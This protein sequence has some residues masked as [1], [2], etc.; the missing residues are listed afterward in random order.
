MP[1]PGQA[2]VLGESLIAL[3]ELIPPLRR[4]FARL[5]TR[6]RHAPPPSRGSDAVIYAAW[7]QVVMVTISLR[8]Q[9]LSWTEATLAGEGGLAGQGRGRRIRAPSLDRDPVGVPWR[10]AAAVKPSVTRH[11]G[12]SRFTR[13]EAGDFGGRS[14]TTM[15]SGPK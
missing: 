10:V 13:E 8:E 12:Q 7:G 15:C 6:T 14:A 1:T 5:R 4:L 3:I 2:D 11:R 9:A